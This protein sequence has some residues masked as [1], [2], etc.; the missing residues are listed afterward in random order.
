MVTF[1]ITLS[2]LAVEFEN[3]QIPADGV[4]TSQITVTGADP[5]DT[6]T[7]SATHGSVSAVTE[8]ADGTYT[9]TYT[10]PSRALRAPLADQI[11]VRSAELDQERTGTITLTVVPTIVDV[12]VAPNTFTA[13][14]PGTTG[15]VTITVT[16]GT[17]RISDE[18]SY[19]WTV[20]QTMAKLTRERLA[21]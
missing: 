17:D 7:I 4:S 10:A 16:R 14:T 19:C 9:A 15:D 6:I 3:P 12:T 21:M 8:N 5:G 20:P 11:T 1:N 2:A 18:D 13:D